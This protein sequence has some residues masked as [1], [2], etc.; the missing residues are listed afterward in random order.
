LGIPDHGFTKNKIQC[1][2]IDNRVFP[3]IRFHIDRVFRLNSE[4]NIIPINAAYESKLNG[5]TI[6][7]N[8]YMKNAFFLEIPR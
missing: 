8:I 6:M 5:Q 3:N 2:L 1:V 7:A 4:D